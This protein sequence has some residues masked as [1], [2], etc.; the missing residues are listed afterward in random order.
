MKTFRAGVISKLI[1]ED[2]ILRHGL[3]ATRAG[4]MC[5]AE[6]VKLGHKRRVGLFQN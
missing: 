5:I 1:L 2:V 6:V 4:E 3:K